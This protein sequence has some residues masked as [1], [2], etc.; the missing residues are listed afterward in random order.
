MRARNWPTRSTP[1]SQAANTFQV[2]RVP[3]WRRPDDQLRS[4]RP[5]ANQGE[6][7]S[8]RETAMNQTES[9]RGERR[10]QSSKD[11]PDQAGMNRRNLLLAGTAMAVVT[12]AASGAATSTAE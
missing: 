6:T 4:E 7:Q 1:S 9:E 11:R 8:I 3:R 5:E 12:A 10:Q 2:R